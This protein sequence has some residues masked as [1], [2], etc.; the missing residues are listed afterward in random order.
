MVL[1]LHTSGGNGR[2]SLLLIILRQILLQVEGTFFR[3]CTFSDL[4]LHRRE[5][6]FNW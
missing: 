3:T 1:V 2:T 6:F 4:F 5:M